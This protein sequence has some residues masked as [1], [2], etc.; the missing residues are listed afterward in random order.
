MMCIGTGAQKRIESSIA[1]SNGDVVSLRALDRFNAV[2]GARASAMEG[3]TVADYVAIAS[4]IA[5]FGVSTPYV[6]ASHSTVQGNGKVVPSRI[7]GVDVEG[8][9]VLARRVAT[10][11][12]FGITDVSKAANVCLVSRSISAF[13][14]GEDDGALGKTIRILSVPFL[15]IGVLVDDERFVAD[16]VGGTARDS[17]V[18]VPFTSLTK[19]LEYSDRITVVAKPYSLDDASALQVALMD[20]MEARRGNRKVEFIVSSFGDSLRTLS[21]ANQNLTTMLTLI[22]AI[23]LLVGG[24]GIMNTMMVSVTERTREIGVRLAIGTRVLSL[25]LL[26]VFEAATLSL[27]AGAMGVVLGIGAGYVVASINDWP[28]SVSVWSIVVAFSSS[29]GIGIFFGFQPAYRAS[30]MNPIEALRFS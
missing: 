30:R 7:G 8:V 26:F 11:T 25:L 2:S 23:S 19:R 12:N 13:L 1:R 3:I 27:T 5:R 6:L 17:T 4:G 28:V 15:V 9:R 14:F 18:L 29:A 21:A 20:L 24:I 22:G 16:S 10:G